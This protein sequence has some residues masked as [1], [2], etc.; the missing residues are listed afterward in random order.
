MLCLNRKSVNNKTPVAVIL[1]DSAFTINL[2]VFKGL[3]KAM[4]P[5]MKP[6]IF[7]KVIIECH[8]TK[9]NANAGNKGKK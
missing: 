2:K 4:L 1:T 8:P 9:Y 7:F 3:P 5:F 6:P